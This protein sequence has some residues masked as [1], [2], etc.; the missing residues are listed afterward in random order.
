[1]NIRQTFAGADSGTFEKICG[2]HC[3][4]NVISAGEHVKVGAGGR[5]ERAGLLLQ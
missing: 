2:F 3:V 1:M 5:G 4:N